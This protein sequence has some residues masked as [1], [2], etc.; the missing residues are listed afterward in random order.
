MVRAATFIIALGLA[1]LGGCARHTP[2]TCEPRLLLKDLATDLPTPANTFVMLSE[3]RTVGRFA[4]AL[5][6]AKFAPPPDASPAPLVLV[7]PR[8]AE[9]A[10]WGEQMRGVSAI[11]EVLFLTPRGQKPEPPDT[12]NLCATA[13]RINAPLLLVYA[14]N[15]LGPNSAQVLGVLYDVTQR[16]P[17]ATLHA[18]AEFRDREGAETSPDRLRGDHRDRD[19]RFQAQRAFEQ[20]VLACLRELIHADAPPTTTQPHKWHQP[21]VERWWLQRR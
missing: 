21:L 11:R 6:I 20:H 5:A 7:E 17:L 3:E 10:F 2:V 8:P 15:G 1:L 9:Q 4:C 19:A 18:S 13:A 16:R 12:E 14:P